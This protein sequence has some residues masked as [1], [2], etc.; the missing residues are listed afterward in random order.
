MQS[1][2]LHWERQNSQPR[3]QHSQPRAQ[4]SQPRAQHS[5]P[6]AQHSQPR[7]QHSQLR[8]QNSQLRAQNFQL[9]VVCTKAGGAVFNWGVQIIKSKG[10]ILTELNFGGDQL[11]S[12]AIW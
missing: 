8:A 10:H 1:I 12:I 4:H 5:Q 9:K 3:A 2:K 6:R 7:A 11:P